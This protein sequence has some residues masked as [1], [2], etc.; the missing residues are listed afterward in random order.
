M[1]T[2]LTID[3]PEVALFDRDALKQMLYAFVKAMA[4]N[5]KSRQVGLVRDKAAPE[6]LKLNWKEVKVSQEVLDMTFQDR[7]DLG[8]N[9][10]KELLQEALTEKHA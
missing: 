1:N 4:V 9:D 2:S 3:M 10:Y 6:K 7:I 8:T 5:V